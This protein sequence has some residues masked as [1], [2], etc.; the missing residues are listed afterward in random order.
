M[1]LVSSHRLGTSSA[2]RLSVPVLPPAVSVVMPV[3][4]GEQHVANAIM[5]VL[6]QTFKGFELLVID[7]GCDDSS[8]EV[9]RSAVG[10]DPRV[11]VLSQPHAGVAQA[12]NL[13]IRAARARWVA[14]LDHDDEF[15]PDKLR[16]QLEFAGMY[17]DA[18]LVSTYGHRMGS[19]GRELGTFDVGPTSRDEYAE[20][21]RLNK[22]FYL[23][24]S[25]V[26]FDRDLV[27]GLGGFDSRMVGIEDVALWTLIAEDHLI[28]TLPDRLVRYRVHGQSLSAKNLRLQRN[29]TLW[30]QENLVRRRNGEPE[31]P[32]DSYLRSREILRPR[33]RV[34][35]F[36]YY[37][38]L[39]S[40]RAAGA[41]LADRNPVGLL[42]LAV[43][44]VLWPAVP[45]NRLRSQVGPWVKTRIEER[46]TGAGVRR[47]SFS[48][49][50]D[51][52]FAD[53]PGS[54]QPELSKNRIA[55]GPIDEEGSQ[56]R[57][58]IRARRVR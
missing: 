46:W 5:S 33:D 29:S 25:S 47:E 17:P 36:L 48:V 8:M 42:N 32:L 56:I 43:S 4:N 34:R 50:T 31:V 13:G 28:L 6:R 23:L 44:A 35:D 19:R 38:S 24:A 26:M 15:E 18:P 27:I 3:H 37:R 1:A 54:V 9:I 40:Y 14:L 20:R 53:D 58:L 21:K 22:V 52:M 11:R 16:R 12:R 7:D 57:P 30:L 41:L 55:K 51:T 39:A 45:I 49:T 10:R 2:V